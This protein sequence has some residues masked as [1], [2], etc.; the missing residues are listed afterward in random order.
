MS[1]MSLYETLRKENGRN[2]MIRV[3]ANIDPCENC[4]VDFV[5][6]S[7][8]CIDCPVKINKKK[9]IMFKEWLLT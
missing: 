8:H 6:D 7:E 3:D 9:T 5:E 2:F 1:E 4:V